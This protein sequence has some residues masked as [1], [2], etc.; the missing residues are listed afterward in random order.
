MVFQPVPINLS[1]SLSLHVTCSTWVDMDWHGLLKG[2]IWSIT[3]SAG[4]VV[5]SES[6]AARARRRAARAERARRQAQA[7]ATR[8]AKVTE[9]KFF[10]VVFRIV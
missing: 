9:V 6:D 4:R 5:R 8:N 3:A 1:L 2:A 10:Q 7:E